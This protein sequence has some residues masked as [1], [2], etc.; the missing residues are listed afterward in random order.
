MSSDPL[1]VKTRLHHGGLPCILP[2]GHTA[3]VAAQR[4]KF[5]NL[6][7]RFIRGPPLTPRRA[8]RLFRDP[9][10][11]STAALGQIIPHPSNTP[12]IHPRPAL[13]RGV[14]TTDAVVFRGLPFF[15]AGAI[16]A[17]FFSA[18]TISCAWSGFESTRREAPFFCP[19]TIPNAFS[20][21]ALGEYSHVPRPPSPLRQ[22]ILHIG[23]PISVYEVFPL[24]R[25]LNP[26]MP[27]PTFPQRI[28][29]RRAAAPVNNIP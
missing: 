24:N 26:H 13:N 29:E 2:L 10:R 1:I 27:L 14:W 11:G 5:I 15:Q 21:K 28:D 20:R 25:C 16:A 4:S 9:H 6:C 22:F 8:E 23:T 19:D 12:S 18:E 7:R 17:R 3:P